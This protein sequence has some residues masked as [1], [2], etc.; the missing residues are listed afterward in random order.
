MVGSV[1]RGVGGVVMGDWVSGVYEGASRRLMRILDSSEK[2][3]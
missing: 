1:V 3:E 2:A